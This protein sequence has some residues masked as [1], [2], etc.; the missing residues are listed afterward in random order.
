M[1]ILIEKDDG[2]FIV[3]KKAGIREVSE[4]DSKTTVYFYHKKD[5]PIHVEESPEAFALK[6]NLV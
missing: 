5:Y 4:K 2:T 3:R 6:H 1:F